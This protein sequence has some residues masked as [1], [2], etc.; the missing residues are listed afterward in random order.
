MYIYI[1]RERERER[2]KVKRNDLYLFRIN[3]LMK[4]F[5]ILFNVKLK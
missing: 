1:Y 3:Y 4:L 5:N 2:D